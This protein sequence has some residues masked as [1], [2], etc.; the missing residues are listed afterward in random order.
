MSI[1]LI[2]DQ[3]VLGR[4]TARAWIVVILT[5]DSFKNFLSCKMGNSDAFFVIDLVGSKASEGKSLLLL[6]YP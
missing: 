5:S 6:M 1:L 2:M 3:S 4:G